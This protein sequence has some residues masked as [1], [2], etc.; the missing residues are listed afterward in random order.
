MKIQIAYL[1]KTGHSKEI[2]KAVGKA[3][4]I[5]PVNIADNPSIFGTDLLFVIGGIYMGAS[6]SLM[7]KFG[8]KTKPANTQRVA[9]ITS[10]SSKKDSQKS[11]ITALKKNYVEILGECI[12][13]GAF[14]L[15]GAGHPNQED[16]D[17]AVAYAQKTVEHV[18]E[19]KDE[20]G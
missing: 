6:H 3:L 2:A 20:Q 7:L 19:K 13:Q 14:L 4:N 10:C 9:I 16:Y 17:T 1:S 11:L 5:K 8:E 12:V 18:K 15:M